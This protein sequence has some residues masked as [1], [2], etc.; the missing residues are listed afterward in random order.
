ML[1]YLLLSKVLQGRPAFQFPATTRRVPVCSNSKYR[2]HNEIRGIHHTMTY[3]FGFVAFQL[4]QVLFH[5]GTVILGIDKSLANRLKLT[6]LND[7]P[8]YVNQS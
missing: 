6:L 3:H 2:N 5:I 4:H 8:A 7:S 1:N